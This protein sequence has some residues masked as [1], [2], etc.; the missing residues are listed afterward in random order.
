MAAAFREV[1]FKTIDIH[2][3]DLISK[4]YS[5]NN[6]KG[7]VACGGFSY[8]DVLGAG[9]GWATTILKNNYLLNEFKKFFQRKNTFTLGVCNGCQMISILKNII[10]GASHF[11]KFETN[12]S[13]R[14]ES[15]T[16]MIEVL[17]SKSIFLKNMEGS[18]IP[19]IISHGEG[20]VANYTQGNLA[21]KFFNTSQNNSYSYPAN[22]NGSVDGA[23]GFTS[24]DGRVTIMMPHPERNFLALHNSWV[25]ND[26]GYYSPWIQMFQ[27]AFKWSKNQ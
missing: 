13:G 10:P 2:M 22:P 1:G 19:T 15:R 17:K 24:Q 14:F 23:T 11:P 7:M 26:W 4:K 27:N 25:S 3:T 16:I 18:I 8:G 9:N 5:L 21:L 6:F 20:R 12:L